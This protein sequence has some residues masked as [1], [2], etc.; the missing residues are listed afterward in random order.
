MSN[1]NTRPILGML[2]FDFYNLKGSILLILLFM[3]ATGIFAQLIGIDIIIQ[4]FPFY[5]IGALPYI[6]L[7][8][9][10]GITN[11][12]QYLISMPI[13]RKQLAASHY[14]KIVIAMLMGIPIV[15]VVWGLDIILNQT[16]IES[17]LNAGLGSVAA[18]YSTIMLMTA[19]LFPLGSTKL[20]GLSEG[21][22]FII[23]MLVA[24]IVVSAGFASGYTVFGLSNSAIALISIAITAAAFIVSM[25]ITTAMYDKM[26]F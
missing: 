9:M 13:K 5:A 24:V 17:Y 8:K 14:L 22:T 10:G 20:G 19:L 15:A 12:E 18:T 4:L 7:I 21:G 1:T 6:A 23:C 26:D 16:A 25:I 11:W 2:K 3:P